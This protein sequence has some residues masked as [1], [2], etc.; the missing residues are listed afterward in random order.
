MDGRS[1]SDFS[2]ILTAIVRDARQLEQAGRLRD[3]VSRTELVLLEHQLHVVEARLAATVYSG[4]I[5][6]AVAVSA[7]AHALQAASRA[8]RGHSRGLRKAV[9]RTRMTAVSGPD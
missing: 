5:E 8:T 2:E 6:H 7:W 3:R 4:R 9:Y 1:D